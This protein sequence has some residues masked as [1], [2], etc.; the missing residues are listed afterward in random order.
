MKNFDGSSIRRR[1]SQ[2]KTKGS[3]F[4]PSH[5]RMNRS[6]GVSPRQLRG[7]SAIMKRSFLSLN[8]PLSSRCIARSGAPPTKVRGITQIGSYSYFCGL[9]GSNFVVAQVRRLAMP[10]GKKNTVR[11]VLFEDEGGRLQRSMKFS[12]AFLSKRKLSRSLYPS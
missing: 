3:A 11:R 6:C 7:A 1:Q 10:P 12:I 9:E 2:G 8:V 4:W 5:Q